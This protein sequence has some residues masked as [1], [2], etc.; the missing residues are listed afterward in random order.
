MSKK[1]D[2][3]LLFSFKKG[4]NKIPNITSNM[5]FQNFYPRAGDNT[6]TE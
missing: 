1:K 5:H 3:L 2:I 6:G 4:T